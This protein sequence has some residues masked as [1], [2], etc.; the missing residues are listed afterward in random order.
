MQLDDMMS[1]MAR[2]IG[3][4]IVPKQ[5][6][7]VTTCMT[8]VADVLKDIRFERVIFDEATQAAEY[9]AILPLLNAKKV[10][11]VGDNK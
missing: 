2:H 3:G 1:K 4:L 9:E 11:L 5:S 10:V 8:S 7:I 6:I